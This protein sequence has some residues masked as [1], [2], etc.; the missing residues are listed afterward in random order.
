MDKLINAAKDY[1]DDD[2]DKRQ[3]S[4]QGH[5]QQQ[6]YGQEGGY[7]QQQGGQYGQQQ[8]HP[9]A[10]GI[11][12]QGGGGF[13]G[14]LGGD[15][16]FDNAK[17]EAHQ[18]AGSSGDK[19][20]FG[21]I[22]GALGQKKNKL[23]DEDLDEEDAIKQHKSTYDNDEP[24]QDSKS[25]GTA[26]AMQALKMYTQGS[27]QSSAGGNSQTAFLGLALAEASKLFDNK[28]ANGKVADGTSKEGV[29]QQA[30]EVALKMYFKQQAGAGG[31]GGGAGGLMSLASK[32]LAK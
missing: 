30:G 26:A 1:L 14:F 25:L 13:G 12:A 11:Q 5:G 21:S 4:Q 18:K 2:K 32:F 8:Q 15:V 16:D 17:E 27:S 20:L 22:L 6:G 28:A 3:E 31:Q 9:P 24:Q 29:I 23:A 7:G 19:D 10:G